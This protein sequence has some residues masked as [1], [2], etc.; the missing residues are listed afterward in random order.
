MQWIV[1]RRRNSRTQSGWKPVSFIAC[2]KRILLRVLL[3]K[4]IH[5]NPQATEYLDAMPDTFQEWL[6]LRGASEGEPEEA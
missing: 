5:P 3:E 6:R 4:D 1:F 2:K